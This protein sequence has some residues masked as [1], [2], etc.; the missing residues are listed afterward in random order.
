MTSNISKVGLLAVSLAVILLVGGVAWV[1]FRAGG[2]QIAP[3]YYTTG[4]D[5][6]HAGDF[7]GAIADYYDAL[8]F[9]PNFA[10]AY[11][12]RGL[13]KAALGKWDEAIADYDRCLELDPR[14]FRAYYNRAF[15]KV[16]QEDV[17]G[18]ILDFN[19]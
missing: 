14:E 7:E 10:R 18:A 11:N 6:Q 17:D 4:V 12:Q 16:S 19:G 2:R 8:R 3:Y 15:A 5:K 1:V 9:N 13:A